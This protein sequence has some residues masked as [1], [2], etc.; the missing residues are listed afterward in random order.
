MTRTICPIELLLPIPEAPA[1]P[2][3]SVL[4]GNTL[5]LGYVAE[6]ATSRADLAARLSDAA[7]GCPQ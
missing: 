4:Q 3:G 1:V 5:G 2:A 7:A 6:L